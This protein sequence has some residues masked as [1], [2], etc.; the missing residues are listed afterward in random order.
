MPN[1]K[2]AVPLVR[3][4]LLAATYQELL[5]AGPRSGP[6]SSGPGSSGPG[7]SGPGSSG[8]GRSHLGIV[9]VL[10]FEN[11]FCRVVA[12]I[13]SFICQSSVFV[14]FLLWCSIDGLHKINSSCY[15][16]QLVAWS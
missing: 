7:S 5:L 13:S 6:G 14:L 15:N 8:P 2:K 4:L 16:V 11:V 3:L 9:I 12:V 10:S 1:K